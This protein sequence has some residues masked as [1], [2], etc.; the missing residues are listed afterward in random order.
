[1][2]S[3]KDVLSTAFTMALGMK[4]GGKAAVRRVVGTAEWKSDPERV[5]AAGAKRARRRQRAGGSST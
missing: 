1:M 5:A 2:R 4:I 3:P